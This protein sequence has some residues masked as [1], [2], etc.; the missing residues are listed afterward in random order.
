MNRSTSKISTGLNKKMMDEFSTRVASMF[1]K[2]VINIPGW[3]MLPPYRG[4]RDALQRRATDGGFILH[5][6]DSYK[7]FNQRHARDN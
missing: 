6:R 5:R 4:Y 1:E 2:N 7:Y 3:K